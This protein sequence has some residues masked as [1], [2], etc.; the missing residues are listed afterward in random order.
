MPQQ[1]EDEPKDGSSQEQG[2]LKPNLNQ[3]PK[4]LSDAA[5]VSEEPTC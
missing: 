3:E 2:S 1:L 5:V 4:D